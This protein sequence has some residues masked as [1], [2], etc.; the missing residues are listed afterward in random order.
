LLPATVLN[1][2]GSSCSGD[3]DNVVHAVTVLGAAV[4]IPQ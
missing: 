3:K 1:E 2:L 4:N